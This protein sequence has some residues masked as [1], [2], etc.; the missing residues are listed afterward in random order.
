VAYRLAKSV[1]QPALVTL[2]AAEENCILS[3]IGIGILLL[4]AAVTGTIGQALSGYS[5]GGWLTSTIVGV[6]GA[7]LGFWLAHHFN[8]P[9]L[10]P[11]TIEGQTFPIV[12]SI[13]ASLVLTF[14]V[15]L[16]SGRAR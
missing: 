4:I 5:L 1:P 3:V 9:L 13:V 2:Q 10:V 6:V 14:I 16:V 7:A 12:W 8:L 11:V 15:G